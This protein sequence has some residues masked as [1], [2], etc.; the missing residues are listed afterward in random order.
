MR[1]QLKTRHKERRKYLN[2]YQTVAFLF[3]PD[4]FGKCRFRF[5]N[6]I[7]TE[8]K[9]ITVWNYV[10]RYDI[11]AFEMDQEGLYVSERFYQK[12]EKES[13][14]RFKFYPEHCDK[15]FWFIVEIQY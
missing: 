5:M 9:K 12:L 3:F 1:E 7:P 10:H 2:L 4:H 13:E 14:R 11:V 6:E 8:Y 15:L